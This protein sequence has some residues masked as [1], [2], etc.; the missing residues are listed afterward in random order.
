MNDTCPQHMNPVKR[1]VV[2][3]NLTARSKKAFRLALSLARASDATLYLVHVVH[4]PPPWG[5]TF[6]VSASPDSDEKLSERLSTK[7]HKKLRDYLH[8]EDI[9]GIDMHKLILTG[10]PSERVLAVAEETEAEL[11]IVGSYGPT[12]RFGQALEH[13]LFE[14]VGA[15]IR[16]LARLPVLTVR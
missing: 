14:G 1:I 8:C 16:R 2:A 11:L 7:V 3:L 5:F 9:E 13:L 10:D 12:S 15:K 4:V 6:F